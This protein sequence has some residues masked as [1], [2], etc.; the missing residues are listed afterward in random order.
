M[1]L[2]YSSAPVSTYL[3]EKNY[4]EGKQIR[5]YEKGE[6]IPL[7]DQ[8]IWQV[9]RGFVEI[10]TLHPTGEDVLLGWAKPDTFFGKWLNRLHFYRAIALSDVYLIWYSL[11]EIETSNHLAQLM[12]NQVIQSMRQTENLL[13]I[14]AMKKVEDRLKEFLNLLAQELGKKT[15]EG[16]EIQIRLTHQNI[17]NGINTTRVTA[18]KML[19]ELQKQGKIKWNEYRHLVMMD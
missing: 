4:Q 16:I 13:A 8:G 12:L 11:K 18:T 15:D 2:A 5:L 10:G 3:L 6:E 17:A 7:L 1:V 19:G 9:Y 14:V